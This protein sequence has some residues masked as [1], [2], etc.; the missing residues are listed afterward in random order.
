VTYTGACLTGTVN[1]VVVTAGQAVCLGAHA[2]VS[3]GVTIDA[4]GSLDMEGATV[5]GGLTSNGAGVLRMCESTVSGGLKVSGSTGLV[6]V[7]GDAAT[8]ACTGN[9]ISGG[10]TIT[11]GSGGVEFN[12][13]RVSGGLTITVAPAARCRARSRERKHRR[14]EIDD[15]E[16]ARA[17]G[18]ECSP[19]LPGH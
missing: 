10:A 8:G 1:K 2:I 6:L 17:G 14:R 7:G 5:S 15:S 11:G 3:S 16:L 18:A 19:P 12:G 9:T 4:G 13:K